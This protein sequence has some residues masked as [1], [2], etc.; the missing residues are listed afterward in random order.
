MIELMLDLR[1]YRERPKGGKEFFELWQK[2]EPALE[3]RR[4][5]PG[6][7]HVLEAGESGTVRLEVIDAR[8]EDEMVTHHTAFA[9]YS[10]LEQPRILYPCQ[11]C[12]REG[13]HTYGPFICEACGKDD[14]GGRCCDDHVAILD[15]S[16]RSTCIEQVPSCPCGRKATF[17]C[18]GRNCRRSKAWCDEHRHPHRH[19]RDVWYCRECYTLEF[20]ECGHAGCANTG[21]IACEHVDPTSGRSCGARTCAVHARRWQIFGPHA[22][23][24]G[25]CEQHQGLRQFGDSDLIYQLVAGTA[26]RRRR[27]WSRT[28]LPSLNAVRH[29][30]LNVRGK[31]Y[32]PSTL[33]Q[34]FD[35]VAAKL[36]RSKGLEGEMAYLIQENAPRRKEGVKK[37]EEAQ[38]LGRQHFEK[39]RRVLVSMGLDPIANALVYSDFRASTNVLYVHLPQQL[40]GR[41]I[42]RGGST[43][44]DI[45]TRVGVEKIKFERS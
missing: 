2:I 43:I 32:D 17:W 6:R 42:G 14:R 24:L 27:G 45:E 38:A 7:P 29:T 23:G 21:T 30:F 12:K 8:P 1:N 31:P 41:L 25:L 36:D 4:L 10:V 5:T 11:Q 26:A 13:K 20:P 44:R 3:G 9:V 39:L 40:R 16:M 35:T 34:L 22:E 37:N 19:N 15:G 18:Q 28:H 33:S